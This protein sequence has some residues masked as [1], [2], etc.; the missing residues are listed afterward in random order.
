MK[1]VLAD[2]IK[3][4]VDFT[5]YTNIAYGRGI[6]GIGYESY[7]THG[8]LG[9]SGSPQTEIKRTFE[10]KDNYIIITEYYIPPHLNW[11]AKDKQKKPYSKRIYLG[12]DKIT[13]ISES[14][15]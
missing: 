7:S 4:G 13:Y 10:L 2:I 8:L 15:K 11:I 6:N 3:R 14:I 5:I 9:E 1:E 12:Y